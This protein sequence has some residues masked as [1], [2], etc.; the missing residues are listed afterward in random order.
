MRFTKKLDKRGFGTEKRWI[1]DTVQF[2]KTICSIFGIFS[3]RYSG[4]IHDRGAESLRN[5]DP[6]PYLNGGK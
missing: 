2:V 4:Q 5:F 3:D 1:Y 6:P